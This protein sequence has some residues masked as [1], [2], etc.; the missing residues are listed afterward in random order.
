MKFVGIVLFFSVVM[1]VNS[2]PTEAPSGDPSDDVELVTPVNTNKKPVD[3]EETL[4]VEDSFFGG[5]IP[6]IIIRQRPVASG[7]GFRNPSFNPFF[8]SNSFGL[9][10]GFPFSDFAF[11]R[12]DDFGSIEEN[13]QNT[14]TTDVETD[15]S[16]SSCGFLCQIFKTLESQIKELDDEF[17]EAFGSNKT[18]DKDTVDADGYDVYNK[19]YSEKV[20]P[21]GSV[22]KV[23]RTVIADTSNDGNSFFF[24]STSFHNVGTGSKTGTGLDSFYDDDEESAEPVVGHEFSPVDTKE[25]D[26]LKLVASS[27]TETPK[28]NDKPAANAVPHL[29]E[30]YPDESLNEVSDDVMDVE[31]DKGVDEGLVTVEAVQ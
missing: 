16:S 30:L 10:N 9:G 11:P 26:E 2:F 31:A 24:H 23:N 25:E 22:V 3:D 29:D 8:G 14:P 7:F 13:S 4:D 19:T 27:T 18:V 12:E 20:L 1:M 17:H 6:V 5:N 21:D 15:D 28:A